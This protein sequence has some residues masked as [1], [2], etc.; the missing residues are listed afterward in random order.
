SAFPSLSLL[1]PS[2][3]NVNTFQGVP[4]PAQK[5]GQ[6]HSPSAMEGELQQPQSSPDE[7]C[8]QEEDDQSH[9]TRGIPPLSHLPRLDQ[10]YPLMP[11]YGTASEHLHPSPSHQAGCQEEQQKLPSPLPLL[12]AASR[13]EKIPQQGPILQAQSLC[14]PHIRQHRE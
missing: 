7:E 6:T 14:T 1:L 4:R 3:L 9:N 12:L 8:A 13:N 5:F 11:A 10:C 2:T